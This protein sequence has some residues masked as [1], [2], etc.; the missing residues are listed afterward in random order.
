MTGGAEA[1]RGDWGGVLQAS[2][3]GGGGPA[4]CRRGLKEVSVA[5]SALSHDA[6]IVSRQLA[7]RTQRELPHD[8]LFL[9]R[10]Y[11]HPLSAPGRGGC[12]SFRFGFS[13]FAGLSL[14]FGQLM[15]ISSA[16]GVFAARV[17]AASAQHSL[18][19]VSAC[20]SILVGEC[21]HWTFSPI[22]PRKNSIA[23]SLILLLP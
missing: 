15:V 5:E 20:W 17:L 8:A 7:P 11:W 12:S 2:G 13:A 18:A 3:C 22:H 6:R 23:C 1:G 10:G 4:G 21:W 14:G 9:G 19:R 16:W